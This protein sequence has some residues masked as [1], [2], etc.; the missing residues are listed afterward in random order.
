M[1]VGA[2][3][4]G[5]YEVVYKLSLPEGQGGIVHSEKVNKRT[6]MPVVAYAPVNQPYD[7]DVHPSPSPLPHIIHRRSSSLPVLMNN[8][9]VLQE[10][11][12]LPIGL[13]ANFLTSCIGLATFGLFWIPLPLLN[14]VGWEEL[15][16]PGKALQSI[17]VICLAG[18]TY[19]GVVGL[20]GAGVGVE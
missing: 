9:G 14:A 17:G 4:L 10:P 13:H 7:G 8:D 16:W 5:L 1:L 19:V 18:T 2:A 15:R 6:A 11:H 20:A 12:H 3:V